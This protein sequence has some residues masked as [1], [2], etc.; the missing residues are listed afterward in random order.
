[1][2]ATAE[3]LETFQDGL[4]D[5]DLRIIRAIVYCR[6]RG[7]FTGISTERSLGGQA[8]I[9]V[10]GL[11]NSRPLFRVARRNGRYVAVDDATGRVLRADQLEDLLDATRDLYPPS[12]IF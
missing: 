5:D 3:N 10:W 7:L 4:S 1:M 12:S 9:I 11:E 2:P 8:S 6:F